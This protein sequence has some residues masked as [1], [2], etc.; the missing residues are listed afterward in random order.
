M[1]DPADAFVGDTICRVGQVVQP[2][3]GSQPMQSMVFAGVFPLDSSDFAKMEESITK[4]GA[5]FR[6]HITNV[7]LILAPSADVDGPEWSVP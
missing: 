7:A 6:R 3:P 5:A 4:V 2:L 1:K